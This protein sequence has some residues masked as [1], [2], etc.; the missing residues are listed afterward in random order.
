MDV[1]YAALAALFWLAIY[2]MARGCSHLER[3]G[4]RQ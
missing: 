4:G 1:V 3:L 2:G